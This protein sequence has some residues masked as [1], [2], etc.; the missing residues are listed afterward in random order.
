MSKGLVSPAALEAFLATHGGWVAQGE[1]QG[2]TL[3]KRFAF[4][5]YTRALGFVV[6]AAEHAE[7]VNHHPDLTLGWRWVVA[8]LT[9]HVDRGVTQ[10]DLDLAEALDRL[11]Q[12]YL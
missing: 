1:A 6:A 9:T 7:K 2:L 4:A 10:R 3:R 11:Y 12:D 8:Q 5:A